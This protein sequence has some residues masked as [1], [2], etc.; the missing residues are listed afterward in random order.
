[1]S[2]VAVSGDEAAGAA[3]GVP[4]VAV[5]GALSVA[6]ASLALAVALAVLGRGALVDA[7][8]RTGEAGEP[9]AGSFLGLTPVAA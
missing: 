5:S 8:A 1:M 6:P 2:S 4:G 3:A 9:E 7:A